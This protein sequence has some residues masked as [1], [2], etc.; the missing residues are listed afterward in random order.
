[1]GKALA[2]G[3]RLIELQ[4]TLDK[5]FRLMKRI[6]KGRRGGGITERA[7]CVAGQEILC[8][9]RVLCGESYDITI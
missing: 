9:L 8:V 5:E 2:P 4:R 3:F 1:M 6:L 7:G